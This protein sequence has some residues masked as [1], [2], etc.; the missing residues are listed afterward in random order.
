MAVYVT[1]GVWDRRGDFLEEM[2]A[3]GR[4]PAHFAHPAAVSARPA[5]ATMPGAPA[6]VPRPAGPRPPSGLLMPTP[7]KRQNQQ[8]LRLIV[9]KPV[10]SAAFS[11]FDFR[12]A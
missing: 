9:Q 5:A 3:S 7:S 8:S 11:H 6:P 12:N 10:A 4:H 2:T 1:S